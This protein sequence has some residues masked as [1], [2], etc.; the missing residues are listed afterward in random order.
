MEL[1]DFIKQVLADVTNA[2][3]ESRLELKNGSIIAPS[4]SVRVQNGM[5]SQS[6]SASYTAQ[7][8]D[9][10]FEVAVTVEDTDD[11]QG[12]ISVLSSIVGFGL[13]TDKK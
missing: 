5:L 10:E 8:S 4:T 6:K 12:R 7:S 9:I 11:K 13:G 3:S 2:V 1:K